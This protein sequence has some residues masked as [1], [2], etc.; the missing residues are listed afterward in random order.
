ME[1]TNR[2][3]T[4]FHRLLAVAVKI[5][6]GGFE[7]CFRL[8]ERMDG[9]VDFRMPLMRLRGRYLRECHS[10]KKRGGTE[11][12]RNEFSHEASGQ[13]TRQ[14]RYSCNVFL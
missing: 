13:L 10:N 7:M 1:L 4:R 12:R 14:L 8:F 3:L 9:F 11:K 5:M 2:S 6:I